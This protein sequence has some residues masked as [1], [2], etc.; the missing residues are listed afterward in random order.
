MYDLI[1]RDA[2]IV[3]SRGREVADV[4]IANGRIAYV[5][6]RPPRNR[7]RQEISAIG[8]FLVPGVI[9]TAV[10]FDPNG[11][12]TLWERESRAAVTGG[13]TS[14]L[15]LPGGQHP[16]LDR[17]S[18]QRRAK[19][20]AA[21]SWC[22]FGLWGA[23]HNGNAAEL[24]RA[25]DEG[26]IVGTLAYLGSGEP[27]GLVP[28][29]IGRFAD[30]SRV[31]G[32]QLASGDEGPAELSDEAASVL[33]TARTHDRPIHLVHLS[34]AAELNMIDPV[35]GDLPVTAGVTPHHLFLSA[36]DTDVQVRTRPPVRPEHD[37]RTLWTAVKRGR[38]DCVASDHHPSRP[39]GE[40]VPGTELLFPLMLSAVKYGRLSLE[41]LVSLCAESPA[42][43]FGL[44][45]KGHVAKGADADLILFS[46]GEVTRIEECALMS[47]A[48]WSPYRDREAAPKPDLVL[49]NGQIVARK[50][51]LVA[52]GPTGH[53]IETTVP[54]TA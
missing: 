25:Q 30:T 5:G 28:D 31:L 45:R 16:V 34:T 32:V 37:R 7:A 21:S 8:K 40:G 41:L 13:V 46:E 51:A 19:R 17:K 29:E 11:D 39:T 44:E 10:Q 24:G 43:I 15:A 48:G 18:A 49:V 53:R 47:C 1:I 22:N 26:L 2:T 52:D 3:S 12:P 20:A 42:R 36:D 54:A 9:D 35:R 14:V 6:P 27:F 23:A 33:R 38:L 50:G 4:A